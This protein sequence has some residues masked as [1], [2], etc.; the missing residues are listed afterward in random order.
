MQTQTT[1]SAAA[2]SNL[3]YSRLIVCVS[4]LE[5]DELQAVRPGGVW[6]QAFLCS[7]QILNQRPLQARSCG[8]HRSVP[9][10]V[11][12]LF[13][14]VHYSLF[15]LFSHCGCHR[16]VPRVVLPL[17]TTVHYSLFRLVSHC[18]HWSVPRVVLSLF[19]TVHYSLVNPLVLSSLC[20]LLFTVPSSDWSVSVVFISQSPRVVF[21]LFTIVHYF[22]FR[23]VCPCGA[24]R[25]I[26]RVVLSLFTIV[27]YFLF[28]LLSHCAHRSAPRVVLSLFTT[29]HYSLFRLVSACGAHR[30]VHHVI[31]NLFFTM[32][33]SDWSVTVV[34][35]QT[36]SCSPVSIHY[37]LFRLV[38]PWCAHR[39]V[40]VIL[41]LFT[42]PSSEWSVLVEFIGQSFV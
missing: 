38:S 33:S 3:C 20:S 11:L 8:A 19:T 18:A 2:N 42:I 32:P 13:T 36:P 29:V 24:H 25:S 39:S 5:G 26:P 16:S 21:S 14:T 23:L 1:K 37:S 28:R 15:R 35:G 31:F 41:S 22:L 10:G 7:V 40:R 6:L 12:S 9:R 4:E 17:F 27:N 30:A 34:I